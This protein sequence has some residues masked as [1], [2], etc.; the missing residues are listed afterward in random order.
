[1]WVIDDLQ[2]GGRSEGNASPFAVR[3]KLR[4]LCDKRIRL[5]KLCTNV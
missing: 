5:F 2:V 4:G 3:V 1:M